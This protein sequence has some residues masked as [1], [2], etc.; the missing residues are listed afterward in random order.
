MTVAEPQQPGRQREPGECE[1]W[2]LGSCKCRYSDDQELTSGVPQ[3]SQTM[4][5][6]LGPSAG[7]RMDAAVGYQ[8]SCQAKGAPVRRCREILGA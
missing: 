5:S 4:D 6:A 2:K 3:H 8:G 1:F 7:G